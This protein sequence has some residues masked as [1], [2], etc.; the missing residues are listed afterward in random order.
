MNGQDFDPH[1]WLTTS[2]FYF[3]GF[4]RQRKAQS[5]AQKLIGAFPCHAYENGN[6]NSGFLAHVSKD[7]F[8]P[9]N[10]VYRQKNTS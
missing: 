5:T 1:R 10:M 2:G 9:E 3:R 7:D 8:L 6:Q 4:R